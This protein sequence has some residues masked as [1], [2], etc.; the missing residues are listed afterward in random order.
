MVL[1]EVTRDLI[2]KSVLC[3]LATVSE[4]GE[5]SVSPKEL[6]GIAGED[7][8]VIADIASAN[9]V[10]NIRNRS[11]VCVSFIEIFRQKGMKLYGE[12]EIIPSSTDSFQDLGEELLTIAGDRFVV[13]NL[14]HVHVD[15]AR[16]IIAPS[17]M[18]FPDIDEEKMIQESFRTYGVLPGL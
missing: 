6:W 2:D 1:D 5:P 10:A 15:R 7:S 12:A 18:F 3:W 16:K 11:R 17:Y 14:I 13:R 8:L 4:T 9:S